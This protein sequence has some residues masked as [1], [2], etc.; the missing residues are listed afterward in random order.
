VPRAVRDGTGHAPGLGLGAALPYA[1]PESLRVV[2]KPSQILLFGE[3]LGPTEALRMLLL[4]GSMVV[5]MLIRPKGLWPPHRHG[6]RAPVPGDG[7]DDGTGGGGAVDLPAGVI[8][9]GAAPGPL[10]PERG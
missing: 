1:D 3:E 7:G 5:I 2:A 4:G 9:G 10:A 6:E 8:P